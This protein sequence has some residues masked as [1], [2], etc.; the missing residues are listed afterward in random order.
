MSYKGP[1]AIVSRDQIHKKACFA[2]AIV[3]EPDSVMFNE[4]YSI[5]KAK[6][7]DLDKLGEDASEDSDFER[8]ISLVEKNLD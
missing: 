1:K 7:L 8:L 6:D 5:Y 3:A 2:Y 4:A